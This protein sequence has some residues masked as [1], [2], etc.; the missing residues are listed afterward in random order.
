MVLGQCFGQEN[1]TL[2]NVFVVLNQVVTEM[3]DLFQS[4]CH[5]FYLNGEKIFIW[6]QINLLS[7]HQSGVMAH[8]MLSLQCNQFTVAPNT[9]F[10]VKHWYRQSAVIAESHYGHFMIR[11]LISQR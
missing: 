10:S 3:F 2:I 8:Y 1:G 6:N 9:I 4:K 7:E 11:F 5:P